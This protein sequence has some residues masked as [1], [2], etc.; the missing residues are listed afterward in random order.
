M[1]ILGPDGGVVL[2]ASGKEDKTP[3][4]DVRI[5]VFPKM[6]VHPQTKEMAMIPMQDFQYQREGSDK[7]WSFPAVQLE[8][9]E[10]IMEDGTKPAG[11]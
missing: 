7:W 5:V 2:S 4:V 6:M 8:K 10:P 1:S 9:H 3:I 11:F